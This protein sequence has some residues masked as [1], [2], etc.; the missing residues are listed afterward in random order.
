MGTTGEHAASTP[1][2]RNIAI[3]RELA[4]P[5]KLV[6]EAWT[7]P[8][9]FVR[10]W[11]PRSFTTPS[12]KIDARPG[13]ILHYCMRS[14]EGNDFWGRGVYREVSPERIVCT[15]TFSD[16]EGNVVEPARYGMSASWPME[17]LLTVTF[18][19]H[20][21]RTTVGLEHAVGSASDSDRDMCRQ[22]WLES[23]DRLAGYLA[24]ETG[25]ATRT[26]TLART[27]EAG[28]RQA[29]A[30]LETLTDADWKQVTEAERWP[31]GVTAHHLAG[32]FEPVAAIIT[33]VASG[34]SLD[35]FSNFTTALL[36]EM[37]AN[38]AREHASCT[39]AETLAMFDKGAAAAAAAVRAVRDEQLGKSA[40]V[41]TDAPPMTVEQLI[42]DA[43]IDHVAEHIGSI[44]KAVGR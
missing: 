12:C 7:T 9:R 11:G 31:V 44:R 24:E 40:T 42:R 30:L 25:T 32:A 35:P 34:Q 6:F 18:D 14:P 1:A 17:A 37:N 13:G 8:E 41:F 33:A 28:A 15:D 38:H 3:T 2:E 29:T 43:L 22:G 27:F 26:Q 36:D 20:D 5:R 4:A 19:E 10:W 23:L 16:P 39:R 21:G